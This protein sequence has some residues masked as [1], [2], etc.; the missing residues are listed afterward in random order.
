M[1]AAGVHPGFSVTIWSGVQE[2]RSTA[3]DLG[4]IARAEV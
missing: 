1:A 4:T 3:T 2:S